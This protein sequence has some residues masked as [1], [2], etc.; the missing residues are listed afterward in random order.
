MILE[1]FVEWMN[2]S[3]SDKELPCR[4]SQKLN[5]K[6]EMWHDKLV[7]YL[8]CTRSKA[9]GQGRVEKMSPTHTVIKTSLSTVVLC[10]VDP[11]HPGSSSISQTVWSTNGTHANANWQSHLA[12]G[13][14]IQ[15]CACKYLSVFRRLLCML[16]HN[17]YV[18]MLVDLSTI[19]PLIVYL[20]LKMYFCI[21]CLNMQISFF[22]LWT[23]IKPNFGF[24]IV[25][26]THCLWF[27]Q[28]GAVSKRL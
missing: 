27:Y 4:N 24:M 13:C 14:L 12:L 5:V 2:T 16:Q 1:H 21:K 9:R 3:K 15:I 10:S 25:I 23:L 11:C 19:L 6:T 26:K 7:L 28:T 8:V 22:N 17:I 20:S 18:F